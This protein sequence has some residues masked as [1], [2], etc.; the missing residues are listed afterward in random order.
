MAIE[1]LRTPDYLYPRRY[2]L[3]LR[4][5]LLSKIFWTRDIAIR[6][7]GLTCML[8]LFQPGYGYIQT[9]IVRR[10]LGKSPIPMARMAVLSL[11]RLSLFPLCQCT[12]FAFSFPSPEEVGPIS[13]R[14]TSFGFFYV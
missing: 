9:C 11:S 3:S 13:L 8:D 1:A 10:A 12:S 5:C 2:Y 7:C 14:A 6:V 4:E